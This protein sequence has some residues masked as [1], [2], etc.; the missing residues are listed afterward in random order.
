MHLW[1]AA[2]RPQLVLGTYGP[3]LLNRRYRLGLAEVESHKHVIGLTGQGKSKLLASTFVQL[4]SQGEACALIDPHADLAYDVLAAMH[5]D[6]YFNQIGAY[7]R[8][9][10]VDFSDRCRYLPFNVLRQPYPDHDV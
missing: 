7:D 9:L 6:G 10:Y 5:H 3:P 4:V 1:P 2:P 8:L